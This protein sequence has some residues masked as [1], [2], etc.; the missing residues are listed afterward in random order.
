MQPAT[1]QQKPTSLL[2]IVWTQNEDYR[3]NYSVP[4]YQHC[5]HLHTALLTTL[6]TWVFN[7]DL[8]CLNCIYD[9]QFS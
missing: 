7:P 3:I 2:Q 9:G 4:M 8:Q 6:L 1:L 5:I